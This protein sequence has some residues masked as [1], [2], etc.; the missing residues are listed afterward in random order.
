MRP[1]HA[2]L[3]AAFFRE[4]WDQGAT[5]EG[6]LGA[7]ACAAAQNPLGTGRDIP[8]WIFLHGGRAVG[9]LTTIPARLWDGAGAQEFHWLKGLMVLPEHRNGPVGFLVVK[10]AVAEVP[11][12]LSMVVQ[13]APRRLFERF[14]FR[15][16]GLLP[17]WIRVLRPGRVLATLDLDRLGLAGLPGPL[18]AG[19]RLSQRAGLARLAGGAAGLG[20][21]GWSAVCGRHGLEVADVLV[22]ELPG[23][24]VDALWDSASATIRAAGNVRDAAY[25]RWRYGA[26]SSGRYRA[27]TARREGR[28]VGVAVVREPSLKG[29]GR[30]R[31]LRVATLSDLLALSDD[32]PALL[33]LLAGAERVASGLSAD[34]L[35]ASTSHAAFPALFRRRAW[36]RLPGNLHCMIR[37]DVAVE[38]PALGGWWLSRG[39]GDADE[40]F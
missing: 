27:V 38:F 1:E 21:A 12:L 35:L 22:D 3:L 28:L 9:Y 18:A 5:P 15:D 34:A 8:T 24:E 40:V 6:V 33:A 31:G 7:R 11:S 23:D 13:D 14:G 20:L 37:A 4:V 30:L 39:D 10:A 29:D 25:L 32:R 17:N 16:L 36:L 26:E 19:V 2:G